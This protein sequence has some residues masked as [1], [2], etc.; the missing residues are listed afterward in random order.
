MQLKPGNC[1]L[2][3][4]IAIRE[5]MRPY[6][7]GC[8]YNPLQ[9]GKAAYHKRHIKPDVWPILVQKDRICR[10][11]VGVKGVLVDGAGQ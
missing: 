7:T 6:G 2:S 11:Q 9:E 1:K 4:A 10:T 8:S 3:P 5:Y